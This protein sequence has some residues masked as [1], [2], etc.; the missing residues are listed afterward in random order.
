[1]SS[2]DEMDL[3]RHDVDPVIAER[4]RRRAHAALRSER[5][6]AERPVLARMERVY[7]RAIEPTLVVGACVVYLGWAAQVTLALLR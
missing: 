4:I 3:A 7:S 1:M 5:E 2:D 6:L